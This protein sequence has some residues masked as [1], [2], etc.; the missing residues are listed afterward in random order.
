[1]KYDDAPGKLAY[2]PAGHNCGIAC[3][4]VAGVAPGVVTQ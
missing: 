1:M 4:G 2:F 3:S